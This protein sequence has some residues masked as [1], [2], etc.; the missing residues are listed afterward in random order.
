L[1][2]IVSIA[3]L[4]AASLL[5]LASLAMLIRGLRA[6]TSMTSRAYGVQRQE[7][8][9]EMLI[10]LSRAAFLFIVAL[11][12]ITIYGLLSGDAEKTTGSTPVPEVTAPPSVPAVETKSVTP[13]GRP[14]VVIETE[15]PPI[16]QDQI[17]QV[18]ST[19]EPA[20]ISTIASQANTAVVNSVNGL[21]LRSDPDPEG[22]QIEL[23]PN[24]TLLIVLRGSEP[25]G[26]PE[27]QL[28]R[29]PSG[30]EGW[31]FIEYLVY[32]SDQ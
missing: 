24:E 5:L 23:I 15:T 29:A 19:P 27:W 18:T 32:Q 3:L 17:Q 20:L 9:K 10:S 22:E 11:I 4:I 2:D 13:T 28:V 16:T 26:Q 7:K 30:S 12:V 31:V 8:R 25:A 6:R 14:T 1:S 21:W